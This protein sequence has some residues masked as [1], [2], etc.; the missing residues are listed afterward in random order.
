MEFANIT[1]ELLALLFLVAIVAGLLDTLAGG[2]GL[3]T[4][5]VL[6][7]SG[8]PPLVAIGT[9]K[10]QGS[11]GTATATYMLLRKNE[12]HW[13]HI[14]PLIMPAFAGALGGAIAVHFIDMSILSF[15]I[16]VVLAFIALFFLLSPT[17]KE[18]SRQAQL[19]TFKYNNGVLPT[20]GFYDGMF[21]PGTGAF[22]ALAGVS[23]KGQSLVRSTAVAKPL[24]FS[25]N[26]ASLFIFLAAGH[27][28]WS[29]GLL[30]MLG[31]II[32]AW[33]G[34]HLLIKIKPFHLRIV[35]VVMST[36]MLIKYIN[37][38]NWL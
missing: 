5:P 25:T 7:L 17:P 38:M 19:T 24:N 28:W 11:M 30:M 37:S 33:I 12:I 23:C 27:I 34:S 9:N 4:L 3:I 14:Q 20:I 22:F 36:S 6:M 18:I 35:I 16:P 26:L 1:L 21:G 2:G 13:Q 10:L 15:I 32:G 29:I 31:Q 8:V